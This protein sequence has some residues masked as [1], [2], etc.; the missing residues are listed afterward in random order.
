VGEEDVEG[1]PALQKTN[2]NEGVDNT[3]VVEPSLSHQVLGRVGEE[4]LKGTPPCKTQTRKEGIRT[5]FTMRYSIHS[6]TRAYTFCPRACGRTRRGRVPRPAK[7]KHERR[8]GQY[9]EIYFPINYNIH[10]YTYVHIDVEGH[11]ALR[12]RKKRKKGGHYIRLH[13]TRRYNIP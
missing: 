12:K 8:G 6:N 4:H 1:Y 5:Y 3:L 7:T 10:Y 2:K 11:A 9:I 13:L